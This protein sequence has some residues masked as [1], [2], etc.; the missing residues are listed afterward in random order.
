MHDASFKGVDFKTKCSTINFIETYG[1]ADCI[2]TL[3]CILSNSFF[4][5]NFNFISGGGVNYLVLE[6]RTHIFE[7]L[8][9]P[10]VKTGEGKILL[11][12]KHESKAE[13]RYERITTHTRTSND[14]P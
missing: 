5:F 4:F 14:I 8:M 7:K 10:H 11:G 13:F 3:H 6:S 2:Q 12:M 1:T 9:E